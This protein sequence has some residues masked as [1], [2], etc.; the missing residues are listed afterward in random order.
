GAKAWVDYLSRSS[1]MLQQGQNVADILYYY[2]ENTNITLISQKS[3]PS[4][5]N[6]LE[7]DYVN[8]SILI[9][10]IKSKNGK[11]VASS[12]STYR[13]LILDESAKEMTLGVLRKIKQLQ[14]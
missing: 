11:L 13:A 3:L 10:D 12:G 4:I 6:D 14:V 1:Y 5:P 8:A 7:F 2:G 9:N